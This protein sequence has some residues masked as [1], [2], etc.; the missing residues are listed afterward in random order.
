MKRLPIVATVVLLGLASSLRA[1]GVF[2]E[3]TPA[4]NGTPFLNAPSE[5]PAFESWNAKGPQF[6]ARGEYVA[7]ALATGKLV[8]IGK[9]AYQ[10]DQFNALL[11]AAGKDWGDVARRLLGNE[12][13]GAR[14]SAGAWLDDSQ[15]IG[16]EAGLLYLDRPDPLVLNLLR[17]DLAPLDRLLDNRTPQRERDRLQRPD[18]PLLM[19]LLLHRI[20]VPAFDNLRN[21]VIVP[22]SERNFANANVTIEIARQTFWVADAI[23]KKRV[24]DDGCVTVDGLLGY[25]RIY[26]E[27]TM[28]VHSQVTT[29]SPPLIPGLELNSFDRVRGET[30]YDG[31]LV[32]VDIGGNVGPWAFALRPTAT[33]AYM[34]ADVIRAGAT[35]VTFPDQSRLNLPTGTYLRSSDLGTFS[36]NKCV[37]I[38]ELTIRATRYL[39]DNFGIT[40]GSSLMYLPETARAAPNFEFGLNPE[41]TL[42]GSIG[43]RQIGAVNPPELRAMFLSTFSAGIEVRY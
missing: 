28:Q 1:Q 22:F 12:R 27:D 36:K 23:G 31:A 18:R 14:L 17:F 10:S 39:C 11:D 24:F 3:S 20:G 4:P 32:G 16:V 42:P 8:E 26:Y 15:T 34:Q 7:W 33:I 35:T 43:T 38:P 21:L 5:N 37:V 2:E 40:F 13:W 29:L 41:R 25:R 19:L 9:E 30:T 6:W